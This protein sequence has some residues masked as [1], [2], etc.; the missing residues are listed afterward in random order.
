MVV[1]RAVEWVRSAKAST[2]QRMRHRSAVKNVERWSQRKERSDLHRSRRKLSVRIG[3]RGFVVVR[4]VAWLCTVSQ[5]SEPGRVMRMHV[6]V[7]E[8]LLRKR[9]RRVHSGSKRQRSNGNCACKRPCKDAK[10]RPRHWYGGA[11][12]YGCH[13]YFKQLRQHNTCLLYTSPS[14]R[15]RG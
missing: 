3:T 13:V 2:A 10:R 11:A 7:Q 6:L 8:D 12:M 15:D 14:P 5:R 9:R 1:R 4:G